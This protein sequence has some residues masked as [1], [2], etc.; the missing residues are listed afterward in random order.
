M[1]IVVLTRHLVSSAPLT[2]A[3]APIDETEATSDHTTHLEDGEM[4]VSEEVHLQTVTMSTQP[5]SDD[6]L[7]MTQIPAASSAAT[8]PE[9]SHDSPV[10]DR[11]ISAKLVEAIA[12]D[13]HLQNLAKRDSVCKWEYVYDVNPRRVPEILM[14]AECQTPNLPPTENDK[15]ECQAVLF[16]VAV[17]KMDESGQWVDHLESLP[18][19]CTLANRAF[20]SRPARC[21]ME[22][23]GDYGLYAEDVTGT[24]CQSTPERSE[25]QGDVSTTIPDSNPSLDQNKNE[26]EYSI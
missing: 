14:K 8:T 19:A 25:R 12:G 13:T 1:L 23:E 20:D 26:D 16:H 10:D 11:C 9:V 7:Q 3:T 24:P 18:V 6:A 5:P 22:G 2:T 21:P 4:E 15:R 17:K